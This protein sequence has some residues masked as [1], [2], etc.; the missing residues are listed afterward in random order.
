MKAIFTEAGLLIPKE[1]LDQW[2][3]VVI[4]EKPYQLI[5]RPKSVTHLTYGAI[6]G[7]PQWVEEILED[8]EAGGAVIDYGEPPTELHD[9]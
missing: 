7:N 5:I 2:G 8:V 9:Q 6:A 1:D 3:E 4:E